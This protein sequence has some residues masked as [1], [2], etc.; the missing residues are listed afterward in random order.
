M[1]FSYILVN[2]YPCLYQKLKI[3]PDLLIHSTYSINQKMRE[4]LSANYLT[5]QHLKRGSYLP[6][7]VFLFFNTTYPNFRFTLVNGD[8]DGYSM[9]HKLRLL[10]T[11][12]LL[13][14]EVKGKKIQVMNSM[15]EKVK[16]TVFPIKEW[17]FFHQNLAIGEL[18]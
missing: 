12:V 2:Y 1:C 11:E 17:Q 10:A 8:V 4:K 9:Q 18:A 16:Q 7:S 3:T 6:D 14:N 13:L 15:K 5:Y